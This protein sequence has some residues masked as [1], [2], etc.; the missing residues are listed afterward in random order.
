MFVILVAGG[1]LAYRLP[2]LRTPQTIESFLSR[3]AAF[4]FNN[5]LLV[6]I[7]FAVF[8]GT[9]FPVL[10]EW[11]RG[12]KITVGPPF[13]NRVNAPLGIG[14]LF[15]M[16]VGP[17]IAWRR[18][19]PGNLRRAFLAP[20]ASGL[21]GG[22]VLLVG[23]V[24]VGAALLTFSLGMFVM[25]TIVQEFWRGMR[26]RQAILHERAPRALVRIVGKNRR[27]YGGYVVHVGIVAMF[28]GIAASSVFRI[29]KQ[30][31]L[32]P[33]QSM[34]IGGFTLRYDR[35]ETKEDGHVSSL[36]P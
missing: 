9:V 21:I 25:A 13:F 28:V 6:G 18:A 35:V 29:E 26:A 11:V 7:A 19:S 33:G 2:E 4:L 12:V 36:A 10:S 32:E 27:R 24:P 15:L 22:V 8:W 5:L 20:V 1:L 17:V 16:G 34:T 14:L 30:Q 23:G 3:E 31:T